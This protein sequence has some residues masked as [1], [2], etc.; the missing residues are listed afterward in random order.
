[1]LSTEE[2]YY[3]SILG[4]K[5]RINQQTIKTKYRE[6]VRQY[7]PYKVS[8]LGPKLKEVAEKEKQIINSAFE[9]FIK[10]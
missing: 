7:H 1:M 3:G 2:R 9:Y 5:G 10:I 4:L 8:H 6:L